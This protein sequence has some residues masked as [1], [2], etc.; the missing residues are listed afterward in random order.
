LEAAS[1]F[2]KQLWMMG[3]AIRRLRAINNPQDH[4]QMVASRKE[5]ERRWRQ[6]AD[7]VARAKEE[8]VPIMCTCLLFHES[9]PYIL[10]ISTDF[11]EAR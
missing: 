3:Q 10:L 1:N 4:Q 2:S 11:G 5:V 6:K 7:V 8:A 9:D